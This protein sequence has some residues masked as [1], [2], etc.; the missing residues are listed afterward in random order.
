MGLFDIKPDQ[1][2]CGGTQ[3]TL[4]FSRATGA[5]NSAGEVVLSFASNL[6]LTVD[7]QEGG[8]TVPRY[9]AGVLRM[10]NYT[11]YYLGNPDVTELDRTTI[12]GLPL[13]VI[14]VLRLGIEYAEIALSVVR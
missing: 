1:F 5:Q 12:S 13:E 6:E 9:L 14:N 11:A 8:G 4:V 3:T 7:L 2:A 10:V